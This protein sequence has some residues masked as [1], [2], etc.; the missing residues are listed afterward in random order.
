MKKIF[1]EF[2]LTQNQQEIGLIRWYHAQKNWLGL[3]KKGYLEGNEQA[4]R[5]LSD[6]LEQ[7]VREK[8]LDIVPPPDGGL[9]ISEPLNRETEFLSVLAR[10]GFDIP[11]EWQ[12]IWEDYTNS[13]PMDLPT[14]VVYCD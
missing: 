8:W 13:V 4:V 7:A 9:Y 6:I 2:V 14:G 11:Q 12:Q 1:T 10:A 3:Q 5:L